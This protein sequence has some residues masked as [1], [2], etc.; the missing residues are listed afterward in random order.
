MKVL[1]T[2]TAPVR[3]Y[4]FGGYTFDV[5]TRALR[6]A[7]NQSVELPPNAV[8]T[9]KY[10][11]M[12]H[13]EDVPRERLMRAIWP[14]LPADEHRLNEAITVLRRIFDDQRRE[15]RFI[16][17]I[18]GRGYRFVAAVTERRD[19]GPPVKAAR[20]A[21]MRLSPGAL[22]VLAGALVIAALLVYLATRGK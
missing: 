7:Q 14:N 1:A 5:A 22:L 10:L 6:D 17:T 12:W 18:A 20:R 15:P 13:G 4:A 2:T 21:P 3:E 8:D 9:L 11:L 16:M 19:L